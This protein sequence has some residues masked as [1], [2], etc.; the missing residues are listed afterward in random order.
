MRLSG[1]ELMQ[2]TGGEWSKGVPESI[3]GISTDS[4]QFIEGHAFLALRGPSFDGHRFAEKIASQARAL[5]GDKEGVRLWDN[6]ETPQL[7]VE[8]TLIALGDIANAWRQR[9]SHT[10]V[11]A[12]TGSY[13]KT[14][15]RSMLN[16]LFTALGVRTAATHANLN[17]LIGVPATLL[18]IDENAEVALIECGISE[19]GEMSRLSEIV[20]PDV[21]IITGISAAHSVGLGGVEGVAHEKCKLT[22]HLLPQ[23]WCLLGRGVAE[24]LRDGNLPQ[25]R[26]DM[27]SDD[28]DIV[29]WHLDGL[30]LTLSTRFEQATLTLALPAAHWGDN[31]ALAATIAIRY[32][33][34]Q[35]GRRIPT[36]QEIAAALDGWQPV[37]GRM[38]TIEGANGAVIIDDSYNANPASMQAALDTLAKLPGRRIAIIGDMAELADADAAHAGLKVTGIDLLILV[39]T[40]MRALKEHEAEALWF[41]TTNEAVT[42]AE[43]N[44]AEFDGDCTVLVKA[45]RSMQLDRAVRTL[46]DREGVHAL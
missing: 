32:F 30:A 10:S 38:K 3:T 18:G 8:N 28:A 39:G 41:A 17:N 23:G 34:Q 16:H 7:Q 1:S 25:N 33:G 9:L 46:T 13:G 2:A 14:T 15:V 21:A 20:Q 12:I 35:P 27:D 19:K 44:K 45:S 6:L 36:L 24:K 11:I 29:Q 5:I 37:D 22:E 40:G 4:R 26:I 42:W 31:M 43:S